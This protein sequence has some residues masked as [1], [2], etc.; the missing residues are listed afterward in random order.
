MSS[1]LYL[2]IAILFN[3]IGNHLLKFSS[4]FL[5]PSF[6]NKNFIIYGGFGFILYCLAAVFYLISLK[7][8]PLSVAY[9]M[10]SITYIITIFTSYFLFKEPITATKLIGSAFILVGVF[11]ISRNFQT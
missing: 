1:Y 4:Q 3:L 11:F 9:P 6:L 10:L 5:S 7:N 8:I 2:S